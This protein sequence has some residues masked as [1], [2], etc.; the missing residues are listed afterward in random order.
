MNPCHTL[1]VI[2]DDGFVLWES[3]SIMQYL[4]NQYAPDSTLYPRD[5][6]K[7]ATVDRLL[8]FDLKTLSHAVRAIHFE[9]T[10]SVLVV[11]VF[12]IHQIFP[13]E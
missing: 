10:V 11:L 12:E 3:R 4:C 7:R 5:F 8:Y 2:D 13:P 1:P 9:F 6:A